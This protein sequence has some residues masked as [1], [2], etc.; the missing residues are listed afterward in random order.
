MNFI[1]L[2]PSM[3]YSDRKLQCDKIDSLD[4]QALEITL[5][6]RPV[7]HTHTHTYNHTYTHMHTH[8]KAQTVCMPS[9]TRFL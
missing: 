5:V 4:L 6:I 8:T 9:R 7:Q 3:C 1:W 2:L